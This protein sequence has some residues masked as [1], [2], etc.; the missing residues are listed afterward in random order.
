MKAIILSGGTGSRL[1][2]L[3]TSS[4]K[5]LLPVYDKPMIY[6]PLWLL[7]HCEIRDFLIITTPYHLAQYKELLGNGSQWGIKIQYAVQDEP[8]GLPYAFTIA[9]DAKFIDDEPCV[10]MLGDN[11]LDGCTIAAD[12]CLVIEEALVQKKKFKGMQMFAVR[13]R[14]SHK[15]GVIRFDERTGENIVVASDITEI[16]EKPEGS[17]HEWAAIGLYL[18]DRKAASVATCLKPSDRKETE[19]LDVF[20]WYCKEREGH[21]NLLDRGTAWF[22][23]G[24]PDELLNAAQYMQVTQ[25][26]Q[27]THTGC[28]EEV[29][30]LREWIDPADAIA[31]VADYP[32]E[33]GNYVRRIAAA[34]EAGDF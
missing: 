4:S 29:A 24:E 14:D 18:V 13:V 8:K 31:Q 34:V 27:G 21:V 26:R 3:T 6:Y 28:L 17:H 1:F 32:T 23:A 10:L 9:Y 16:I 12:V 22:D 2:P 15:Y 20:K 7:M 5:Q 25:K 19:I 11:I 33:Y 30:L